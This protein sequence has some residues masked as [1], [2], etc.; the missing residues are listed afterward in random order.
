ME[1]EGAE[2]DIIYSVP[3]VRDTLEGAGALISSGVNVEVVIFM[4]I[5][6][7][8]LMR[9]LQL[10]GMYVRT[11]NMDLRET[12]RIE[13]T[14]A[15]LELRREFGALYEEEVVRDSAMKL[16]LEADDDK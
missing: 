10:A 16:E 15:R 8:I 6:V 13:G 11:H 2:G 9:A 7:P 14:R 12:I 3:W 5:C 1:T 4:V